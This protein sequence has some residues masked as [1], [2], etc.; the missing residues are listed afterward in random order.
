MLAAV[1]CFA[2][3]LAAGLALWGAL[4]SEDPDVGPFAV[5]ILGLPLALTPFT[6]VFG[7][8][9][10]EA[11]LAERSRR[12][13]MIASGLCGLTLV[14]LLFGML[15]LSDVAERFLEIPDWL[16]V[17]AVTALVLFGPLVAAIALIPIERA[18]TNASTDV[19]KDAS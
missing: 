10:Q 1:G 11:T 8:L 5:V 15:R 12:A 13:Q 16:Q 4:M 9:A 14:M 7:F 3:G 18:L 17:A 19:A 2:L 6:Y